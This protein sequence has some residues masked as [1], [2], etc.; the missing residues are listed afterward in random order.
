MRFI[1][2]TLMVLMLMPFQARAEDLGK[3]DTPLIEITNAYAYATAPA[4]KNGAVF[5]TIKNLGIE[6]LSG[7]DLVVM[8]AESEV[9]DRVELHT[10]LHENGVMM[11]RQVTDFALPDGTTLTLEP[12]GDHIML[13]DLKHLL[14]EGDTFPLT[15][16]IGD[17]YQ[18]AYGGVSVDVK[19]VKPGTNPNDASDEASQ[20]KESVA[21]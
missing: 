13:F 11:M 12:M 21:Q 20:E 6:H 16:Y 5:A 10:H 9:S 8:K 7:K 19:I 14:E 2:L 1:L 3:E 17:G 15:I 4:Q 18:H